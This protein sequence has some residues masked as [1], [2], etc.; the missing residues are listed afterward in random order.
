MRTVTLLAPFPQRQQGEYTKENGEK[1]PFHMGYRYNAKPD[2]TIEVWPRTTVLN[3]T[4]TEMVEQAFEM[5]FSLVLTWEDPE[6]I[7]MTKSNEWQGKAS[8]CEGGWQEWMRKSCWH[9]SL[10]IDNCIE[11]L[12]TDDGRFPEYWYQVC[13]PLN[14][15]SFKCRVRGKF[16]E[17]YELENFPYDKQPLTVRMHST[18]DL[19]R[20]KFSP[21]SASNT[22]WRELCDEKES[23]EEQCRNKK[24]A[25]TDEEKRDLTAVKEN[26]PLGSDQLRMDGF[27]LEEWALSPLLFTRAG[28]LRAISSTRKPYAMLAVEVEVSRRATSY[29]YNVFLFMFCINLLG[30][31]VIIVPPDAFHDRCSITL[32][33]MLTTVAFK[34]VISEKLPSISYLTLADWYVLMG[35]MCLVGLV[36]ANIYA[37]GAMW[38]GVYRP[39]N[40]TDNSGGAP[41][42]T[43][44]DSGSIDQT[45][46]AMAWDIIW[47]SI[48]F[49]LWGPVWHARFLY[50]ISKV[51]WLSSR[52][53]LTPPSKYKF[54]KWIGDGKGGEMSS[55]SIR[56]NQV[57]PEPPSSDVTSADLAERSVVST[58]SLTSNSARQKENCTHITYRD[59][60]DKRPTKSLE[61]L[62]SITDWELVYEEEDFFQ[63][64]DDPWAGPG[65]ENNDRTKISKA[66]RRAEKTKQKK[67]KK[68][69]KP[70]VAGRIK[71]QPFGL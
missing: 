31:S 5:E 20:V 36:V 71:G 14:L 12:D 23:L 30:F 52:R 2:D 54:H 66:K 44:P 3:V 55:M 51:Y 57:A 21:S 7:E 35:F 58:T 34:Y 6:F 27:I 32:T 47:V 25:L 68:M 10:V 41:F 48:V 53:S 69:N 59:E 29:F 24:E 46:E 62:P 43:W 37:S 17:R 61:H 18:W 9:P 11:L 8:E 22:R 28:S 33:L 64:D 13:E 26:F 1:A 16:S 49:I 39:T 70:L 65:E 40:S 15:V 42:G 19:K 60:V 56:S 67:V 4:N 45:K 38:H 63:G 50:L